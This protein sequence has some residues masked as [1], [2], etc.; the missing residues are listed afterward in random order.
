MNR[1]KMITNDLLIILLALVS[2]AILLL[3]TGTV[4]LVIAI[5]LSSLLIVINLKQIKWYFLFLL[6]ANVLSCVC[7]LLFYKGTGVVLIFLTLL[8]LC[9][10]V[11]F[12]S[13]SKKARRCVYLIGAASILLLVLTANSISFSVNWLVLHDSYGRL[14]NN[15]TLGMYSVAFGFCLLLWNELR[16]GKKFKKLFS[17]IIYI[18]SFVCACIT[19]CRSAMFVLV[20][21]FVLHKFIKKDLKI[22]SF[23]CIVILIFAVSLLFTGFYV[24]LYTVVPN[25]TILGKSLFSGRESVWSLAFSQI[26][27]S[28]LFGT[29]TDYL[30]GEFE[31]THN[32]LLGI[33]KNLGLIPLISIMISFIIYKRVYISRKQQIMVI[34]FCIFAFFETFMMDLRF[35]FLFVF[36]MAGTNEVKLSK[37]EKSKQTGS[38]LQTKEFVESGETVQIEEGVKT[39]DT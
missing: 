5:F 33:L 32:M 31:S 27:K 12:V 17:V 20:L 16:K 29:G 35:L 15:N 25:A 24:I 4:L 18:V 2:L 34:S 10:V 19:G 7:T 28:P 39:N 9:L 26:L 14:V 37:T 8:M 1:I 23:R 38:D 30:M 22:K 21:Y 3:N 6:I 13:F 11:N 36:L